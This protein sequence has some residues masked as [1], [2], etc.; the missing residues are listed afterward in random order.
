MWHSYDAEKF[1]ISLR[2][3]GVGDKDA[4]EDEKE[5]SGWLEQIRIVSEKVVL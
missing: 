3:K 5:L 4:I 1:Q 2:P